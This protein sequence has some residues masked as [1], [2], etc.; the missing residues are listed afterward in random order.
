MKY[1][2][3]LLWT[4]I[5]CL[6]GIGMAP[7]R[8]DQ[9]YDNYLLAQWLD[10]KCHNLAWFENKYLDWRAQMYGGGLS[11]DP[12]LRPVTP[13]GIAERRNQA[14]EV[15]AGVACDDPTVIGLRNVVLTEIL[16]HVI[17][18]ASRSTTAGEQEAIDILANFSAGLYGDNW[19][20]KLEE[21]KQS[22][23]QMDPHGSGYQFGIVAAAL[24]LEVTAQTWG[25]AI[26]RMEDEE[27]GRLV[28]ISGTGE[29]FVMLH[30]DREYAQWNGESRERLGGAIL[31]SEANQ[32]VFMLVPDWK[33]GTRPA[34]DDARMLSTLSDLSSDAQ[35]TQERVQDDWTNRAWRRGAMNTS[36]SPFTPC[37]GIQCFAPPLSVTKYL[38]FK[39]RNTELFFSRT[40]SPSIPDL[41]DPSQR[42]RVYPA[43]I[44]AYLET[45][46]PENGAAQE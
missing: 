25:Y 24:K 30:S 16:E 7:A 38:A 44:S 31:M 33:S 28:P 46:P 12:A 41:S 19:P 23:S 27:M 15:A 3:R 43:D 20:A 4:A 35:I 13:D 2:I 34:V 10:L 39:H 36:L 29:S 14:G 6:L 45:L 1:C 37:P 17:I 11:G 32:V 42:V 18:M 9:T 8:A 26:E 22:A 21:I 5:A 40:E